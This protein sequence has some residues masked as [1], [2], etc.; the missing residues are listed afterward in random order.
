MLGGPVAASGGYA[1]GIM[2]GLSNLWLT[3]TSMNTWEL[4]REAWRRP[5][6]ARRR[7]SL[8]AAIVKLGDH[9]GQFLA[10]SFTTAILADIERLQNEFQRQRNCPI[11]NFIGGT[12]LEASRHLFL[13]LRGIGAMAESSAFTITVIINQII[14]TGPLCL[15]EKQSSND[16]LLYVIVSAH[17]LLGY[18]VYGSFV[19]N[20]LVPLCRCMPDGMISALAHLSNVLEGRK[21]GLMIE[22]LADIMN[23]NLC[24]PGGS[25]QVFNRNAVD[26]IVRASNHYERMSTNNR[27]TTCAPALLSSGSTGSSRDANTTATTIKPF[28]PFSPK[29]IERLEAIRRSI[30]GVI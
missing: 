12:E 14:N 24:F 25:H 3:N 8:R 17:R 1:R 23:D 13:L 2:E 18:E 16:G 6:V 30:R 26:A 9:L 4:T 27:S 10:T 5:D 11:P 22:K 7:D 21:E 15:S 28:F 20:V 29:L 19:W